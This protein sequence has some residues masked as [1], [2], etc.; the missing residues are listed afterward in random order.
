MRHNKGASVS[1]IDLRSHVG[2]GSK[3][4]DFTGELLTID[5]I[6]EV[7]VSSKVK[8]TVT[9]RSLITG[10]GASDVP[11]RIVEILSLKNFDMSVADSSDGGDDCTFSR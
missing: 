6:S 5:L 9:L 7:V 4:H 8:G 1:I 10:Y 3:Q 11:S 2:I